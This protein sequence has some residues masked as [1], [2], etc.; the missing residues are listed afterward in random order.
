ML[1]ELVG[2]IQAARKAADVNP[3]FIYICGENEAETAKL[4]EAFERVL[5]TYAV[6]PPTVGA[7][8]GQ[9]FRHR[10]FMIEKT[11]IEFRTKPAKP[12]LLVRS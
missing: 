6:L 5:S 2:I 3:T 12:H 11:I 8:N 7:P 9:N 4:H 10:N 1:H